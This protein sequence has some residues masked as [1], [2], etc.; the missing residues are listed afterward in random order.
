MTVIS[1][2]ELNNKIKEALLQQYYIYIDKYGATNRKLYI[3]HAE[4]LF[5]ENPDLIFMPKTRFCGNKDNLENLFQK[6]NVPQKSKDDYFLYGLT[7]DNYKTER[8]I[9]LYEQDLKNYKSVNKQERKRSPKQNNEIKPLPLDIVIKEDNPIKLETIPQPE[10]KII[11]IKKSKTPKKQDIKP[12][13]KP[14]EKEVKRQSTARREK[15]LS[16][17]YNAYQL[18]RQSL[19]KRQIKRCSQ[20]WNEVKE[21][22]EEYNKWFNKARNLRIQFNKEKKEELIKEHNIPKR[23]SAYL[24][25]SNDERTNIKL[26]HPNASIGE[27]AKILADKWNNLQPYEKDPYFDK[28]DKIRDEYNQKMNEIKEKDKQNKI[29]RFVCAFI[30]FTS[31]IRSELTKNNPHMKVSEVT[32]LAKQKWDQLKPLEKLHYEKISAQDKKRYYRQKQNRPTSPLSSNDVK[33]YKIKPE[34]VDD[35]KVTIKK[36]K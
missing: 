31:S 8:Y 32:K 24:L 4:G 23:T 10:E 33:E 14:K 9:Q 19:S 15:E 11:I 35:Y 28:A 7:K 34:Y 17:P 18:F 20:L 16:R 25:W 26:E 30:H 13:E 36:K 1:P 29:K 12:I 3:S 22:Q 27:I 21:D 6:L 5:D 2:E